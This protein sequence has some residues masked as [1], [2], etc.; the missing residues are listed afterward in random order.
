MPRHHCGLATLPDRYDVSEVNGDGTSLSVSR[1]L[2]GEGWYVGQRDRPRKAS[3]GIV[4]GLQSAF[5]LPASGAFQ[6]LID[7]LDRA[8]S[9]KRACSKRD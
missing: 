6:D 1:S 2:F 3:D 5:P 7:A 4:Q 8:D 9:S